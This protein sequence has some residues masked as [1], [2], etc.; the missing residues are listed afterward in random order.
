M[1]PNIMPMAPMNPIRDAISIVIHSF[2]DLFLGPNCISKQ[3]RY[4][5]NN[6]ARFLRGK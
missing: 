5:Y 3:K 6:A 1:A 4:Q 2:L